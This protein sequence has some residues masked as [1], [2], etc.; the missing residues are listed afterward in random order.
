[1]AKQQARQQPRKR[2]VALRARRAAPP[3]QYLPRAGAR[4]SREAARDVGMVIE[5]LVRRGRGTPRE[6]LKEAKDPASPAHKHFDWDPEIAQKNWLMHQ[7]T[8]YFRS[9]TILIEDVDDR[10]VPAFERIEYVDQDGLKARRYE[11]IDDVRQ[12]HELMRQVLER[13]RTDLLVWIRRFGRYQKM[14]QQ[15]GILDGVFE[16]LIDEFKD[17]L[18]PN[19][20]PKGPKH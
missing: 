16:V 14:A 7:A 6:L 17:Q 2:R 3:K 4:I 11:G 20:T 8:Q 18:S 19:S 5:D 9:I 12:D 1:M 10:P 13:A 15:L